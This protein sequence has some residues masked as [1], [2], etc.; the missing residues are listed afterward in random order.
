MATI[1]DFHSKDEKQVR[2]NIEMAVSVTVD[3]YID[4]GLIAQIHADEIKKDIYSRVQD[5][6]IN[7]WKL[8]P[9]LCLTILP[10]TK[11][12]IIKVKH[13]RL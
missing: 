9:I 10:V 1:I 3:D 8:C 6:H 5:L 7:T 13:L 2:Q 4:K 11:A 12:S